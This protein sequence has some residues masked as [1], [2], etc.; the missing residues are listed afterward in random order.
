MT[1]CA[2]VL[3]DWFAINPIFDWE[4]LKLSILITIWVPLHLWSVM[5]ARRDDYTRGGI[6]YFPLNLETGHV[7]RLLVVLSLILYAA[8]ITVYFAGGFS[9][10]F[11]LLANLLGGVLLYTSLRLAISTSSCSS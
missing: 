2:P 5:I 8:S 9:W 6:N 1:S 3:T 7:V 11:L 10:L 4:L